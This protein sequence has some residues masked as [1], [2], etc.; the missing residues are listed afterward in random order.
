M[1]PTASQK[2]PNFATCPLTRT[3]RAFR[4]FRPCHW[5]DARSIRDVEG[6]RALRRHLRDLIAYLEANQST[7]VNYCARYQ[8]GEP[9][10][11]AFAE[12]TINEIVAKRMIKKQQMRWNRWTV[13]PFLDVRVAVLDGTLEGLFRKLYSSFRTANDSDAISAAT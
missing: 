11:T 8:R 12:S 1:H 3:S 2:R 5:T 7:L 6:V 9:I 4:Y 10:S 13:Q